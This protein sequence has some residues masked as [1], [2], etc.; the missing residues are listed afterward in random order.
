MLKVDGNDVEVSIENDDVDIMLEEF[1]VLAHAV[2]LYLKENYFV[3]KKEF[4][5]ILDKITN[6]NNFIIES[7]EYRIE[8][9]LRT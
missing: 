2:F 1:T 5:K 6:E 3:E 7:S 4:G 8:A 9:N